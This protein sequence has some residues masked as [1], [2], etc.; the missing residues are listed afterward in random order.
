MSGVENWLVR[1]LKIHELR[2]QNPFNLCG[3][4]NP[5]IRVENSFDSIY[6]FSK[7]T[8][9][10]RMLISMSSQKNICVHLRNLRENNEEYNHHIYPHTYPHHCPPIN[11]VFQQDYEG[12]RVK[13]KKTF[14]G[15]QKLTSK[16][17]D[18]LMKKWGWRGSMSQYF[19]GFGQKYWSNPIEVLE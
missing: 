15:F 2:V 9:V 11:R 4:N 7:I 19:Y 13:H 3:W 5:M 10:Y 8:S 12:V 1:L 16:Q 14:F 17:V 6:S 18:E